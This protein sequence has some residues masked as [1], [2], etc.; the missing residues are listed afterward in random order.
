MNVRYYIGALVLLI[1]IAG[2]VTAHVDNPLLSEGCGSC[3]VGHGMSGEPMLVSAEEK[4]CYQCHGTDAERS[5]M[6]SQGRLDQRASL[7]NIEREF[8]KAWRHPVTQGSGHKPDERLPEGI[9]GTINHAECVDCHNP[10]QRDHGGRKTYDVQ[11]YSLSGQYVYKAVQ[12]Y[13]ICLKCHSQKTGIGSA[14]RAILSEFSIS[15]VSQHPVTEGSRRG[16]SVSLNSSLSGSGTM[17]CTD[18][19]TNDDASG[20]RG[21]HGS[22]YEFLLSGRYDRDVFMDES[23]FAF[24]FCYS[25][26][27]RNSILGNESF[28]L[29]REHIMGDP[30]KGIK[31]T[32]CFTCHASH[33]SKTAPYLIKFNPEAVSVDGR[34]GRTSYRSEGDG[35][36]ECYLKC[37]GFSHGPGRY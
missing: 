9:S 6:I 28:S 1:A 8:K 22:R 35:S 23:P 37:H 13:E 34:S 19:H 17:K 5:A 26:H 7:A 3:H 11:G 18:C 4:F 15:V 24:E 25:C 30:I 12:E 20:P 36:G 33:S 16:Q 32:S 21:P 2:L 27:D 31:G 29:H 14:S 10:H